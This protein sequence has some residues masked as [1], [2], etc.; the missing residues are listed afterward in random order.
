MSGVIAKARTAISTSDKPYLF[1][2][3]K[4]AFC[5]L[6]KFAVLDQR[7]TKTDCFDSAT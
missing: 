2:P 5:K 3:I 6:A 1:I 4:L 7:Q